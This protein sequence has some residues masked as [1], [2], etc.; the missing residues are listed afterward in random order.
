MQYGY[1]NHQT[2]GH[3]LL[4]GESSAQAAD[5]SS[6]AFALTLVQPRPNEEAVDDVLGG[7][8]GFAR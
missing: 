5:S 8:G 6:S 7:G 4:D 2:F 3:R 1:S